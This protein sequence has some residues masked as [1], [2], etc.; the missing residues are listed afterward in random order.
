MPVCISTEKQD[1]G[2]GHWADLISRAASSFLM[3]LAQSVLP[4]LFMHA[5]TGALRLH[6]A[7]L[8]TAKHLISPMWLE[9]M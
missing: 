9:E 2:T 1:L 8:M 4:N 7:C 6:L 3:T 5:V